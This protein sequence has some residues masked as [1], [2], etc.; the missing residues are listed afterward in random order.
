MC[1]QIR[2]EKEFLFYRHWELHPLH[3]SVVLA[4]NI[5]H[6]SLYYY[7]AI[8][9]SYLHCSLCRYSQAVVVCKRNGIFQLQF[10][11]YKIHVIE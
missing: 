6:T 10:S 2:R 7:C 9:S 4:S 5:W 1:K 8:L 3:V 11:R